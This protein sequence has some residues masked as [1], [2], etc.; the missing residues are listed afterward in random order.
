VKGV[1]RQFIRRELLRKLAK[2]GNEGLTIYDASAI[3]AST[4]TARKIL[5]DFRINGLATRDEEGFRGAKPYILTSV[6]R[7]ILKVA[8]TVSDSEKKGKTMKIEELVKVFG[9][10][11][12]VQAMIAC[13][14]RFQAPSIMEYKAVSCFAGIPFLEVVSSAPLNKRA[15][16]LRQKPKAEPLHV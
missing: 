1:K 7:D 9:G 12:V 10:E 13:L 15:W 3:V 2:A 8:E 16:V 4:N 14:L 6:G 11:R 5:E